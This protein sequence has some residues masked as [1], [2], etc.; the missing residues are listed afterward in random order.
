[1]KWTVKLVAEVVDGKQIEHEIATIE[2]ADGISPA[3]FGLTIAEGKGILESLQKEIVTAQVQH[4]GASIPSCPRCGRAYR[5]KGYYP[6][7]LRSVYGKVGMRIR[8]LRGCS[9]AGSQSRSFSTLFTNKNPITPELRYLTAKMAALLPFGK[10]ADF[11]GELLPLSARA[12]AGTVRN[13]TMK[14][15]KRLQKSAEVLATGSSNRLCKELIVGLDGG[16]VRNRHQ[17]PERN[18]E[19]IAG[20][21]LDRDGPPSFCLAVPLQTLACSLTLVRVAGRVRPN[22]TPRCACRS[23]VQSRF[24]RMLVPKEYRRA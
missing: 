10:V 1:M 22:G 7:T 21:A 19:V 16:Y 23:H 6:P 11:L 24:A 20:K 9:C 15:G 2:R 5:T 18:F 17:R 4:H 14:V 8:R 13:R 3:T 12:T